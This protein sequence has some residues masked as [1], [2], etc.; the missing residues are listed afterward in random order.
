MFVVLRL[1]T[2]VIACLIGALLM[3]GLHLS[4]T[5]GA[6]VPVHADTEPGIR[7]PILMYH[8]ITEDP[9]K[10]GKFVISK[11][12]LEEDLLY[13]KEMGYT[14]VTMDEV[15]GYVKKGEQ[16]PKKP[17]ILTFDDG[18]YNNYCY[19]YPLLQKYQMKAVISLIGKYTDL[20]SENHEEN[21]KYSHITWDEAKE[22]M[23]SGLVEFQNHSYDMHTNTQGRD[24][25]KKKQGESTQVYAKV[26]RDDIL[27]LQEKMQVHIGYT[28]TTFAYPFGSVSEDSYAILEEMGFQAS[29]SCEEKINIL[30]MGDASCL[31]MLNRFLRSNTESA[32]QIL[33]K[34]Q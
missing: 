34:V 26:L 21:P 6:G 31:W 10:V 1:R 23:E 19:A 9:K 11:K 5:K 2:V 18:Y 32:K 27:Y 25:T 17:I 15:I 8:G 16:L 20:Y 7:L 13:L 30:K 29:L 14:T 4:Q 28:P 3:G 24:G 22:M 12:M 33:E